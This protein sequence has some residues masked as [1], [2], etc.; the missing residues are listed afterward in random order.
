MARLLPVLLA[1]ALSACTLGSAQEAGES[2]FIEGAGGATI[3]IADRKAAPDVSGYTLDGEQLSLRDLDGG[4]V[5]VNFWAS[6]CG[7]CATEAPHL[8][9]IAE[10][11]ADR[12]VHLLGV[13]VKDRAANA[14][15]FQSDFKL[16][17]PSLS[18]E[19]GA[20]AA[21]F[22][23]IGPAA[24]PTT[25]ILDRDHRVAARLFGAVSAAQLSLHLERLLGEDGE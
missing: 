6:W 14:R 12:G 17:Y 15:T 13:N 11:Y 21:A 20:I 9:A 2:R 10:D 5:L 25:I 7:P 1:L 23:G 22:G 8:V 19:A 16:N 4:P 18:D 24:L 3:A